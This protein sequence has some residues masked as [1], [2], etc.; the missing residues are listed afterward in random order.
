MRLR[1]AVYHKS[2]GTGPLNSHTFIGMQ[3]DAHTKG[4]MNC[5]TEAQICL[6]S[7]ESTEWSCTLEY[8][9]MKGSTLDMGSTDARS[10]VDEGIFQGFVDLIKQRGQ[11]FANN[12]HSAEDM[13][14]IGKRF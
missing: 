13:F 7:K 5:Y 8:E 6:N 4:G 2:K 14:V 3:H 9:L 1:K 10:S 12:D 11:R